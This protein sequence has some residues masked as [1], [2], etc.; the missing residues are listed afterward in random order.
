MEES[1][2]SAVKNA[3]TVSELNRS[4]ARMLERTFPLVRVQGEVWNFTRAA[5]G[6]WYFSLKDD[7][8][9]V[10]CA[11]FRGRSQYAEFTPREGDSVEVHAQVRLYEARGEYQLV[12]DAIRKA[13]LGGLLEAFE[14]LKRRLAAEGLFDVARKRA[15]PRF[16]TTIGIVTSPDAAALR[17]VARTLDEHAPHVQAIVY[18]TPV[19]GE[20][21]ATKIA[22]AIELAN[23]RNEVQLL[24][25]CRGGGS[26]EDLWAFNDEVVARA[27]VNSRIPVVCGIGHETDDTIA[28]YAADVRAPTP[29]A[30]ARAAVRARAEWTAQL[31]ALA[32][33]VNRAGAR[34]WERASMRLD[35]VAARLVRPA[36]R[37]TAMQARFDYLKERFTRASHAQMRERSARLQVAVSRWRAAAP[38]ITDHDERLTR[39]E[40]R[41]VRAASFAWKANA[42]RVQRTADLLKALGPQATVNRGYAI[43]RDLNGKVLRAGDAQAGDKLEIELRDGYVGARVESVSSSNQAPS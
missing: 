33:H 41:L 43:V 26:L 29:T 12:V 32:R 15:L 31:D 39:A 22:A 13:G 14:R 34:T 30:A 23:A 21:A 37:W 20:G 18:P 3:V 8:A 24:I 4:V 36:Q 17:D 19:Q 42:Q 38:R 6:H 28:D 35:A 2:Q 5:S 7:Q 1:P 16:A 9:Q 11:M 27:I 40:R 10:R 25:V